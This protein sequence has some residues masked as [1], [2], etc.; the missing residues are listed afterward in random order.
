MIDVAEVVKEGIA[1]GESHREAIREALEGDVPGLVEVDDAP[2]MAWVG[3]WMKQYPVQP[4]MLETGQMV[5][6]SP[7]LLALE[8]VDGGDAVLK[9]IERIERTVAGSV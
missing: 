7:W 9:R 4:I 1:R 3:S 5:N 2:F 6:A 8:F